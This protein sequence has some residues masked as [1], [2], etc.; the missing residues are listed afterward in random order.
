MS[1]F[2]EY[3]VSRVSLSSDMSA[4]AL[5]ELL[6]SFFADD[7]STILSWRRQGEEKGEEKGEEG[8]GERE[9]P[10]VLFPISALSLGINFHTPCAMLKNP[11]S[12]LK[13]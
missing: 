9:S 11:S 8:G 6:F 10:P 12:K 1:S 3:H 2:F 4:C 13:L 5:P 7:G